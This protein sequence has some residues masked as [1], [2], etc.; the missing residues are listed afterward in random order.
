MKRSGIALIGILLWSAGCASSQRP[1]LY[2]NDQLRRMGNTT[3]ERDIDECMARAESYIASRSQ[4]GE[5]LEDASA[6]AASRATVGATAGAAGGAVVGHAG[7][8]AAIGAAGG[9]AAGATR[10][11]IHGMFGTR[12]PSPVHKNFVNRCLREKGYE[13]IGWN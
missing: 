2:P 3:A 10:G 13:P 7:T 5:V 8:G 1:V 11:L 12:G 6:R 4:T 9:A